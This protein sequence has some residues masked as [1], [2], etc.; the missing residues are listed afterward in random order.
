MQSWNVL[1][2]T[3]SFVWFDWVNWHPARGSEKIKK[4]SFFIFLIRARGTPFSSSLFIQR[5]VVYHHCYAER[6]TFCSDPVARKFPFGKHLALVSY[7][8]TLSCHSCDALVCPEINSRVPAS[9]LLA[10]C[11]NIP[12]DGFLEDDWSHIDAILLS[13]KRDTTV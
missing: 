7:G 13:N 1:P 12:Q 8:G 6:W 3:S 9:S 5:E 11:G 4:I 10:A 2:N